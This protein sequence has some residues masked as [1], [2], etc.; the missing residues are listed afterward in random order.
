MSTAEHNL[1]HVAANSILDLVVR[2]V[3]LGDGQEVEAWGR[4]RV[5]FL[6]HP[7]PLTYGL[8]IQ[9]SRCK[10]LVKSNLHAFFLARTRITSEWQVANKSLTTQYP[11]LTDE[12]FDELLL[13]DP[14]RLWQNI[15]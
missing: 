9:M 15:R 13:F 2:D 5:H 4:G 1:I 7:E 8:E 6:D 14:A 3:S 11:L 10:V 12:L